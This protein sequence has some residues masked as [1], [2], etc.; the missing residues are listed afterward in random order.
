ML[1]KLYRKSTYLLDFEVVGC[2]VM[3]TFFFSPLSYNLCT[4]QFA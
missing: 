3:W 1:R 4:F 2:A